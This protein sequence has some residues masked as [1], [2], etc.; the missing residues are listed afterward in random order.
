MKIC[1]W[2][3][4]V[5]GFGWRRTGT[6]IIAVRVLGPTGVLKPNTVLVRLSGFRFLVLLLNNAHKYCSLCPT[7]KSVGLVD[8]K[9]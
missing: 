4:P 8:P 2:G 5:G 1:Y 9:E 6:P 3:G 7:L